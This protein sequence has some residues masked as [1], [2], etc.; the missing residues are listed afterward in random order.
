MKCQVL[1]WVKIQE[2]FITV[3][4]SGNLENSNKEIHWQQL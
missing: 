3:A 1:F 4:T 2:T